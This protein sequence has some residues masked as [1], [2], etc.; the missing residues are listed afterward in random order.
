MHVH[1]TIFLCMVISYY[2]NNY[3]KPQAVKCHESKKGSGRMNNIA[4]LCLRKE[5]KEAIITAVC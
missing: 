5:C 3:T 1:L 2:T 4:K